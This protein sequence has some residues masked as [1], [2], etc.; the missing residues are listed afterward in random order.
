MAN[1]RIR[2]QEINRTRKKALQREEKIEIIPYKNVVVSF[3]IYQYIINCA[4]ARLEIEGM[5][6][7]S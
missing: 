2:N 6:A 3:H 7:K 4:K 5:L 1:R